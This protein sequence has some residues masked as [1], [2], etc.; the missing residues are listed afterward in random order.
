MIS[1]FGKSTRHV[2]CL[3]SEGK[4]IEPNNLKLVPKY[5]HAPSN[6]KDRLAG[7]GGGNVGLGRVGAPPK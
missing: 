7:S 3:Y 5:A 4:A 2:S 1:N 6:L